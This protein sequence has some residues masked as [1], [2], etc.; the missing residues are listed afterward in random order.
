MNTQESE[1]YPYNTEA[2]VGVR[3]FLSKKYHDPDREF[4]IFL[5]GFARESI[6][7]A[8]AQCFEERENRRSIEDLFSQ[9]DEQSS[10]PFFHLGVAYARAF[11]E[12]FSNLYRTSSFEAAE[13]QVK[14]TLVQHLRLMDRLST[15][16]LKATRRDLLEPVDGSSTRAYAIFQRGLQE[17]ILRTREYLE[18]VEISTPES[19][20]AEEL[21]HPF[22]GHP[23]Y[24]RN[25]KAL[26]LFSSIA[27]IFPEVKMSQVV[28][29]FGEEK[30]LTFFKPT[31]SLGQS[32][33]FTLLADVFMVP[34]EREEA[35]K[36]IE[37]E[38]RQ[39]EIIDRMP[40]LALRCVSEHPGRT[41]IVPISSLEPAFF[42]QHSMLANNFERNIEPHHVATRLLRE[43]ERIEITQHA[44]LPM[45][46]ISSVQK[47]GVLRGTL[48]L[49]HRYCTRVRTGFE[50]GSSIDPETIYDRVFAVTGMHDRTHLIRASELDRLMIP[51]RARA[52]LAMGP[53]L[54]QVSPSAREA[55][56]QLLPK[57]E[58]M[59]TFARNE[60]N[61]HAATIAALGM[62]GIISFRDVET[63]LPEIAATLYQNKNLSYYVTHELEAAN[64]E[65]MT[66]QER[67]RANAFHDALD[68]EFDRIDIIETTL[69]SREH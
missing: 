25:E 35:D 67:K 18:R 54:I 53:S 64:Q 29:V 63:M 30:R 36:H 65:R 26:L 50:A 62:T 12:P 61:L 19:N 20:V 38:D 60:S 3:D 41:P 16:A 32:S 66:P 51:M 59:A 57:P 10:G 40:S 33:A 1:N 37:N 68:K 47:E 56:K 45:E 8:G 34:S 58:Q 27:T 43:L 6:P 49:F 52:L 15:A 23:A 5:E 24:T 55:V 31:I 4:R 46:P 17:G 39:H 11:C 44:L 7:I 21:L 69:S 22:A 28:R 2:F 48:R 13:Q 9:D 42:L 14:N